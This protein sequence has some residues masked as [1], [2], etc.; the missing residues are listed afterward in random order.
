MKVATV[1]G[2]RPEI[3]RL[4][5]VMAALERDL[6]H[7][8]VHTGQNYDYELNQ[9]FF[10]DLGLRPPDRYLG[11][12]AKSAAE[13]IGRLIIA[14]DEAF[15]ELQ[16][17]AVLILGDTNSA[18]AAIPAKRRRIPVFHMEA[19]NRCFDERVPE[20]INRRI[21]DHIADINLPYSAIS[22]EYLLREGLP[23][24]RVIRTGSPMF[25]VLHHYLPR[26]HQSDV[27]P[28]LGLEPQQFFVV[29][30]HREENVDEPGRLAKLAASLQRLGATH[31]LP[32]VVSTHPRTRKR[33]EAGGISFGEHARLLKPLGF[34]DYVRLE[35]EARAVL[36]DSGTIT[37]ESSILNFPALNIREAHERPEGMEEGAVMMTGLG[38]ERIAE[39]LRVLETQKRGEARTLRMVADYDT[40]SV[41]E[42]VLRIIISYTDYVNRVVWREQ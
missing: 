16:P 6:D 25:E 26:I 42:K 3:I 18:L 27:L 29:S 37:E 12:A 31:R 23:P 5:R 32:I 1:V 4:S 41:S 20:E 40:G 8:L 11:A 15:E 30:A 17:E 28:R 36:S 19:G 34:T 24:D 35:L 7:V 2:T 38:W 13:T 33:I 14:V 22:R 39:G 21:V 9:V 10:E